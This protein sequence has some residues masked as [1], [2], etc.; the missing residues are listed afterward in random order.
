MQ[1][2]TRWKAQNITNGSSSPLYWKTHPQPNNEKT[3]DYVQNAY[4]NNQ[5]AITEIF[6][7]WRATITIKATTVMSV[8]QTD[9]NTAAHIHWLTATQ[10]DIDTTDRPQMIDMIDM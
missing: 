9:Y 6:K 2:A 4:S 10:Q 5:L 3:T 8:L 7:Q 1:L